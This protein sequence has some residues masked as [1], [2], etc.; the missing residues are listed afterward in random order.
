MNYIYGY[1][2]RNQWFT[3]ETCCLTVVPHNIPAEAIQ[4][5]LHDNMIA[6]LP[7]GIF[8]HLS[9]CQILHLDHN[10][11][12]SVHKQSFM[13]LKR[14]EKLYLH[15]NP[16]SSIDVHSFDFLYFVKLLW[17]H[18][19]KLKILSPNLFTNLPRPLSLTLSSPLY[20]LSY[21]SMCW[22]KHEEQH[23]TVEWAFR[24][25]PPLCAEGKDWNFLQCGVPGK[26]C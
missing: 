19:T 2:P 20:R 16:L 12:L 24:G 9:Q 14:L 13:G 25:M 3:R 11:I 26:K 6:S 8:H 18:N 7:D 10:Q 23:G 17:L 5:F 22:L 1:D 21:S 4:I 15:D